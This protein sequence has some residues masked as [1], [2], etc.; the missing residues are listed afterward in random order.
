MSEDYQ[1]KIVHLPGTT[2]TPEVVLHRTLQKLSRIKSVTVV[3]Q[4]DDDTFDVDWSQQKVSEL[5]MGSL[6]LDEQVRD[7]VRGREPLT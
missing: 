3:I 5:C 6:V 7:V 1:P 4:W 2:L